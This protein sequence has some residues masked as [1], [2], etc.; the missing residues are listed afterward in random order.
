M[1]RRPVWPLLACVALA[2]LAAPLAGQA[3]A[4]YTLSGGALGVRL[5]TTTGTGT[6][7]LSGVAAGGEGRLTLSRWLVEVGY[8]QGTLNPRSGNPQTRDLVEGRA[9][10]GVRATP[11]LALSIGPHAR[12]YVIG[13]V[14]ER[15]IQWEARARVDAPIAGAGVRG[16]V[17]LRGVLSGSVAN[18]AQTF[19]GGQGG[20]AGLLLA[21][22]RSPVWVRVSY[23]V[24]RARLGGGARIDTLEG[25]VIA[26][27]VGRR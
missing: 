21:L 20:E 2:P 18:V 22:P 26:L 17:E 27:G 16:F 19:D 5:E 10:V 12:G 9:M 13:G 24:D 15:F 4:R 7:V 1:S 8:L 23:A 3:P 14:T 6:Q 25:L 11:W